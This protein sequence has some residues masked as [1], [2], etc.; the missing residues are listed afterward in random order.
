M[1]FF[2]KNILLTVVL[3]LSVFASGALA[4]F[5]YG[6]SV[7]MDD[8]RKKRTSNIN[9][10][11]EFNNM[12]ISPRIENVK[13][14]AAD[15]DLLENEL[16]LAYFKFGMPYRK[17]LLAMAEYVF[18][19]IDKKYEIGGKKI[20]KSSDFILEFN[21]LPKE[22][23]KELQAKF[24]E[25]VPGSY[26][27]SEVVKYDL[28]RSLKHK[29]DDY[30]KN[31][32]KDEQP[33]LNGFV[34]AIAKDMGDKVKPEVLKEKL[35]N[36]FLSKVK[37]MN[38]TKT[39]GGKVIKEEVPVEPI[40]NI[41][42]FVLNS[43]GQP[44]RMS[45]IPRKCKDYMQQYKSNLT[46]YLAGIKLMPEAKD[47]S[48]EEFLGEGQTTTF[49]EVDAIPSIVDQFRGV[50]DIVTSISDIV[51]TSEE[52]GTA[53]FTIT[54]ITR[55]TPNKGVEE[56]EFISYKYKLSFQASLN[57]VRKCINLI[58][59]GGKNQHL[60]CIRSIKLTKIDDGIANFDENV[61]K[62]ESAVEKGAQEF[63]SKGLL[64]PR[65]PEAKEGYGSPI[66]GDDMVEV[67][68]VI[69]DILYNYKPIK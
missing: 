25:V 11:T 61:K 42:E 53:K 68:L 47:F 43:L 27:F 19:P 26:S 44:V 7:K 28:M 12:L 21:K 55:L 59:S 17:S 50:A 14:M 16:E 22:K 34:A 57:T 38:V 23:Q 32:K 67:T 9:Q 62:I 20:T 13:N 46:E 56:G 8:L 2:K 52:G 3:T 54:S 37:T 64:D 39:Q 5:L 48:F 65:P 69:D 60:Y 10:I 63:T 66:I 18:M 49:P 35:I 15:C 6:S 24:P 29:F 36:I 31:L 51:T 58:E 30:K 4:V 45:D 1:E 33:T 40:I 41:E